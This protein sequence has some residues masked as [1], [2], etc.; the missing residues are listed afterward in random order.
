MGRGA[1]FGGGSGHS[2]DKCDIRS[3]QLAGDLEIRDCIPLVFRYK[4]RQRPSLAHMHAEAVSRLPQRLY[5][6]EDFIEREFGACSIVVAVAVAVPSPDEMQEITPVTVAQEA[7]VSPAQ[8]HRTAGIY[9]AANNAEH[10]LE[11][12]VAEVGARG[13]V[14][15]VADKC[16]AEVDD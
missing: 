5:P 13:A 2:P 11:R 7:M 6:K 15:P 9:F 16:G 12:D 4:R 8:N 14:V 3:V 1:R 10:P